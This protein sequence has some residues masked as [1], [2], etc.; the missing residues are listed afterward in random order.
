MH[1]HDLDLIAAYAD[2]T[3]QDEDK[4]RALVESCAVCRSEFESHQAVLAILEEVPQA[5]MTEHEKAALH[6][7]LW[8]ELRADA[9]PKERSTPWWYR[10]SYA[11][12]GLLIV[13]GVVGVISQTGGDVDETFMGAS[14]GLTDDGAVGEAATDDAADMAT[15]EIEEAAPQA[16]EEL[17]FATWAAK[18][19]SAAESP[20][21]I[22]SAD[23]EELTECLSR[24]GLDD[25]RIVERLEEDSRYALVV[26]ADVELGPE[27]QIT[28]VD[29]EKC[30][31]VHIDG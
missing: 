6:R 22:R 29:L 9:A 3:L 28:F 16:A 17:D 23:G 25:H 12:A 11:A 7:D 13:V 18:A 2:G 24:A 15:D 10:W 4:A 20:D 19:R 27:T 21:S 5:R 14:S 30:E 1:R 31:V 8:T 26:A